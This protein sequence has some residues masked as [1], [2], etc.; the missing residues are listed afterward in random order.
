MAIILLLLVQASYA[1]PLND[2]QQKKPTA[3]ICQREGFFR[4]PSD[5]KKFYRCVDWSHD[6]L[7]FTIFHFVCPDGTIFDESLQVSHL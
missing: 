2:A 4:Y 1:L 7:E 5:C 6:G 3:S